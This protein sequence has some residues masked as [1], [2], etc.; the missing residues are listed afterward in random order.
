MDSKGRALD[1]I[2]IEREIVK[3]LWPTNFHLHKIYYS[4]ILFKKSLVFSRRGI[5]SSFPKSTKSE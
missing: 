4:L 1:N 5:T 3:F 2:F